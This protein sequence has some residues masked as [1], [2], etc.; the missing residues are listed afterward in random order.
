VSPTARKIIWR[1]IQA[2]TIILIFYY[3]GRQVVVNWTMVTTYDWRI[4]YLLLA[5]SVLCVVGTFF[6]FSSVWRFIILAL[7]RQ[8]GHRKAFKISYI[9]NLGRYI[10]GRIWQMFGMIYLAKKEG[11]TE[12]EALTSFGMNQLFGIP[13]GLLAGIV[14]LMLSPG[15]L[16][17]YSIVPFL[18][19]GI[20]V[21]GAVILAVSLGVVFFPQRAEG[22]LN[23]IFVLFKR[24]PVRL[25]MNK[26][27]AAS[28]YG[29]YFLGWMLYGVSFWIF[30]KGTVAL[31]APFFALIGLFVIAY[32]IGYL[33]LFA[34]GGVG[35]REAVI[36][37]ML[38]PFCGPAVAA[39]IAI[40]SRLWL[41]AA[42]SL[43]ALIAFRIK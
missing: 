42:E 39:A 27:L 34:P 4:N 1:I 23:R 20:V 38:A 5:I 2:A 40:A 21:V 18:S 36:T 32:Q 6:V 11:I 29:G 9:A 15:V 33:A 30:L 17:R 24:H 41:I 26:S 25:Q 7:G 28:I 16:Q 43:A 31:E 12:E 8:I 14:C 13:S 10:P 37:L 3:L 22:M 35:P 19:L